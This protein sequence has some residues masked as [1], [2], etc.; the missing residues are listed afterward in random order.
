MPQT[1]RAVCIANATGPL[2]F[3][4]KREFANAMKRLRVPEAGSVPVTC[5]LDGA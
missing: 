4:E 1:P 2:T 5:R 3:H